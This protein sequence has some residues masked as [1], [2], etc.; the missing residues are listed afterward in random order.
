MQDLFAAP[1]VEGGDLLQGGEGDLVGGRV[2]E[3]HGVELHRDRAVRHLPGVRLLG[4][5]R[6]EVQHLEDP[7]KADQRAHHLDVRPGQRGQRG[8]EPGEQQGE[9][10]DRAGLQVAAQ[11]EEAAEPVDD[12]ERQGG[13]QGECGD[14]VGLH[15]RR[16][17]ADVPYPTGPE[18]E[19]RRFAGRAA[20]QLDEGG[21]GRGE[22]FGHLGAHR[23][24]VVGALPPQPRKP[25]SDPAGGQDEHRQQ[26]ER[27]HG[28][29]PGQ[30]HHHHQGQQQ[31]HDV[32]DDPGEGVAEGALGADHIVVEAADQRTCTG[33]GEERDRH[34]LDVVVDGGAQIQDQ[35]L[36]DAR[37]QPPGQQPQARLG[38]RDHGDQPGQPQ[39]DTGRIAAH[40]RVDH[41]PGE[42]RGGHREHRGHGAQDQEPHQ[43]L[44][45]RPGEGRD[46][47]QGSAGEAPAALLRGHG[48]VQGMPGGDFHV[49]GGLLSVGVV[50]GSP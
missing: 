49:H 19:F 12:G 26:D 5:Q 45:V 50:T 48:A 7:L 16:A 1:G 25:S 3:A 21:A 36:A 22:P 6:L 29:L 31:R 30:T 41:P 8:V 33:A 9:R 2:G 18:G 20:H 23:G 39:D 4:D 35:P 44:A 34:P 43:A 17:D 28:D 11:G 42:Q 47:A 24:V 10:D 37:R 40:D 38:E 46:P 32:A 15:H 14:E 13:D 27:D